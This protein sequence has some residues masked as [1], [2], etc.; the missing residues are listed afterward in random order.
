MDVSEEKT[1]YRIRRQV[2]NKFE[3]SLSSLINLK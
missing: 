2:L 3:I 1:L